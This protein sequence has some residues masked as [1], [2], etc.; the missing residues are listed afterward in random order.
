MHMFSTYWAFDK[1]VAFETK[2][3]PGLQTATE[4]K[5]RFGR[6]S[7]CVGSDLRSFDLW[8]LMSGLAGLQGGHL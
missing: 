1:L 7:T 3:H 5:Q 2:Q 6:Y 8:Y 4:S